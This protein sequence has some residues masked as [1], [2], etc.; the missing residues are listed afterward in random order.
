LLITAS[1]DRCWPLLCFIRLH[2]WSVTSASIILSSDWHWWLTSSI[3]FADQFVILA[4]GIC[5]IT[6]LSN[7][8]WW[9][10][11]WFFWRLTYEISFEYSFASRNWKAFFNPSHLRLIL[12][13][14]LRHCYW[15]LICEIGFDH[16]LARLALII[17][18]WNWFW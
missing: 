4:N 7:Q 15:H 14:E 1:S 12:M 13:I 3:C 16:C 17:D 6:D 5:L 9:W 8:F 10:S 2:N 11:L 18:C